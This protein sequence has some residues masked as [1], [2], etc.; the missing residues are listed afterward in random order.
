MSSSFAPSQK[1]RR[2]A[3]VAAGALLFIGAG[4][5]IINPQPKAVAAPASAT[6]IDRPQYDL[7]LKMDWQLLT[8]SANA[9]IAVPVSPADPIS[10]ASFFLFANADGVGGASA[11]QQNLVVD[12]VLVNGQKVLWNLNG[13]VLKVK[14][15][16][17]QSRDVQVEVR[18]HGL[19]PRSAAE[20]GGLGGMMGGDISSLFGMGD[21]AEQQAKAKNTDYGLYTATPQI[22]SLG[23]FWSPVLAVRQNGKW[24]D[25]APSGLGDVA[26]AQK[27]DYRVILNAPVGMTVVAPG[28]ITSVDGR[29]RIEADNVRDCAILASRQFISKSKTISIGQRPVVVTAYATREHANRLT[30]CVDI[31]ASA[32]Q[33][34]SRRFGAYPF[35]EFKVVEAPMKSG[36]GGMEYSRMVG[37]AS[38]LYEPMSKQLGGMMTSLNLPGADQLLAQL[39][40]DAGGDGTLTAPAAPAD[41]GGLGDLGGGGAD[42]G[43]LDMV[44][45]ILGQQGQMLDSLLEETIAHEVAHQWWAIGVG[46]NSQRDPWVDESLT[47]WSSMLYFEDRYGKEK[48]EQMRELHLKTSFS[49]GSAMGGGDRAANLPSDAYTNN[50]QYGAVVYGKAAL[51]YD[52]LRALVGDAV[53]FG[54]LHDYF[55]RYNDKIA[56][57]SSLRAIVAARAPGKKPQ[58]EALYKRWIEEAHGNEDIGAGMAG[59][60]TQM[61]GNLFGGAGGFGDGDG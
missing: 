45:G 22:V 14:F 19:V 56:G 13:P 30:E 4:S 32:L 44:G 12:D 61:I 55:A 42:G 38:S 2:F 28:V 50:L 37:I 34:Y 33:I 24:A 54:A 39:D 17:P 7:S 27:S 29:V 43:A 1:R 46:S 11:T 3:F 15:A 51:F 5:A 59:D 21:P 35:G 23:S 60:L 9:K 36:A 31:A 25:E 6:A 10:D 53:F 20:A 26:Y 52:H 48:A 49:M 47:N 58:I 41:A 8:L 16:A 40:Q 18:Y 57:P